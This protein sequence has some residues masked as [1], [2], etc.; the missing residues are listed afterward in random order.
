MSLRGRPI[1]ENA[2]LPDGRS[3]VVRVGVPDDSYVAK[4]ALET[5]AVEIVL[6]ERIAASLNT[7]LSP[8]HESEARAL[9]LEIVAGLEAGELEPTAA[10]I[11]PLADRIPG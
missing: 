1:E 9:A 4:R 11:E 10:A 6:D 7:V 8:D 5:I 3:A 2:A